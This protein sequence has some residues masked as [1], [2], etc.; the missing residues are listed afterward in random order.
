MQ[1]TFYP[2]E[3]SSLGSTFLESIAISRHISIAD[4]LKACSLGLTQLPYNL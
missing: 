1:E 2:E 4:I 3:Q